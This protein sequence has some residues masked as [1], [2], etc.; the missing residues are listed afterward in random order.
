MHIGG[1]RSLGGVPVPGRPSLQGLAS[2]VLP[3]PAPF[4]ITNVGNFTKC[5]V[6]PSKMTHNLSMGRQL[7]HFN[8]A[9]QS[10]TK[11]VDHSPQFIKDFKNVQD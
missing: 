7:Q 1:Q 6:D 11:K 4:S 8:Y 2:L 10:S 9:M 3:S 5:I